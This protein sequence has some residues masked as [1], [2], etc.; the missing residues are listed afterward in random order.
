[1][2]TS[3]RK[4]HMV[5]ALSS[6]AEPDTED[7][8]LRT[9][10]PEDIPLL[11]KL[12]LQAYVGTVD[13]EGESEQEAIEAVRA[14]FGGEFGEFMQASSQVLVRS[15]T[16]VSASFITLWQGQP[17]LAFSVTSPEHKGR[18]LAGTCIS[19]SMHALS[20]AGYRELHLFVTS[21]NGPALSVYKRLGF[22]AASAA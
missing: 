18:G 4:I 7:A 10:T 6:T 16:L 2:D 21:T 15:G 12:F 20:Q 8:G 1:M 22:S 3:P 17:L 5:R 9:M 14:T 11:G 19:A 13:Y